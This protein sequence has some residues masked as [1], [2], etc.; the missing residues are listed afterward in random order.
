MEDI[1]QYLLSIVAA[2]LICALIVNLVG[3]EG[4]LLSVIKLLCGLFLVYT[5]LSPWTKIQIPGLSSYFSDL[6]LDAS[7]A[8]DEGKESALQASATLI[9]QQVEAYILDKALS[10]DMDISIEV[11]MDNA[12]TQSPTGVRI[13]GTVSPYAKQRL[14]QIISDELGIPKENQVW[15]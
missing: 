15:I 13:K 6:R 7:R 2:A 11:V 14:T 3:K 1:R 4:I 5:I 8:V 10:L 12:D 9:K